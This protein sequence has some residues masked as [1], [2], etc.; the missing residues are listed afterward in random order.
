MPVTVA[1]EIERP[2]SPEF[3]NVTDF[4]CVLPIT[5]APNPRLVGFEVSTPAGMPAPVRAIFAG[6]LEALLTIERE[7]LTGFVV[8]GVKV[9]LRLAL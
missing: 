5:T 2:E 8:S 6:L 4:V 9:I 7:L 1:C 3:V